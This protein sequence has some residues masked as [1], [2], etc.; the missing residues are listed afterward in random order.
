MLF[1]R[2]A[3]GQGAVDGVGEGGS[4]ATR[5]WMAHL[6]LLMAFKGLENSCEEMFKDLYSKIRPTNCPN[7]A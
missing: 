6:A 1:Y 4:L 3:I 5:S 2:G 7:T